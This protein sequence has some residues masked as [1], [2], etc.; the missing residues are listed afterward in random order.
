MTAFKKMTATAANLMHQVWNDIGFLTE[1]ESKQK[2][3]GL[4]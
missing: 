4:T 1:I 2:G 3:D